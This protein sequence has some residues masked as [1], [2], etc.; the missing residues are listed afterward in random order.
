[1][2]IVTCLGASGSTYSLELYPIGAQFNK[3]SG[4]YVFVKAATNGKWDALYVGE[5]GDLNQR[6]NTA[7]KFHQTWP[8]IQ[9]TGGTH[10]AAMAV[11]GGVQE[12][13]RVETDLRHGLNPPLNLQ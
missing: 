6:L 12:R 11:T 7:L 3:V 1:M 2:E 5:A 9:A 13:L 4:V 8:R 10:V